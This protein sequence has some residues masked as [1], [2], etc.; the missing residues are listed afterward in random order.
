MF[1]ISLSLSAQRTWNGSQSSDWNTAANWTP[2]GVPGAADAVTIVSATNA[3]II[4]GTAQCGKFRI[5][6]GS[7]TLIGAGN[8]LTANSGVTI[9][10]GLLNMGADTSVKGAVLNVNAGWDNLAGLNSFHSGG[11]TVVFNSTNTISTTGRHEAF[12]NLVINSAM[13]MS[14]SVYVNKLATLNAN[15]T[16]GAFPIVY[17]ESAVSPEGTGY[18]IGRPV[19]F[20][21]GDYSIDIPIADNFGSPPRIFNIYFNNGRPEKFRLEYFFQNPATAGYPA[22]SVISEFN[23]LCWVDRNEWWRITS[24]TDGA[25]QVKV[26][27]YWNNPGVIRDETMIKVVQWTVGD[28]GA[29]GW[30]TIGGTGEGSPVTIGDVTSDNTLTVSAS[31]EGTPLAFGYMAPLLTPILY[32]EPGCEVTDGQPVSITAY[33]IDRFLNLRWY[34]AEFGG[35]LISTDFV[36]SVPVTADAPVT[37]WATNNIG[38]CESPRTPITLFIFHMPVYAPSETYTFCDDGVSLNT[39]TIPQ[40]AGYDV[41][42]YLSAGGS[43]AGFSNAGSLTYHFTESGTI[44][45]L[46]HNLWCDYYSP[47]PIFINV[48]KKPTRPLGTDSSGCAPSVITLLVES[49]ADRPNSNQFRWYTS[50]T[51]DD[52]LSG[53]TGSAYTTTYNTT[54]SYWVAEIVPGTECASK[55]TKVTATVFGNV[56]APTAQADALCAPGIGHIIINAPPEATGYIVWAGPTGSAQLATSPNSSVLVPNV[57]ATMTVYAGYRVKGCDSPR[58]PVEITLGTPPVSP[59]GTDVNFCRTGPL[60][61]TASSAV[62]G[63]RFTWVNQ[64]RRVIPGTGPSVTVNVSTN[65]ESFFVKVIDANGCESELTEIIAHYNANIPAPPDTI[66]YLCGN[67]SGIVHVP[68]LTGDTAWNWY[69]TLTSTTP[70]GYHGSDLSI[71]LDTSILLYFVSTIHGECESKRAVVIAGPLESPDAPAFGDSLMPCIGNDANLHLKFN[72]FFNFSEVL[73]GNLY[74]SA[75]ETV[76]LY[77]FT[78]P[79]MKYP[80]P[81]PGTYYFSYTN[82]HGCEGPRKPYVVTFNIAPEPPVFDALP[83]FCYGGAGIV[84]VLPQTPAA[85]H[86]E[87]FI[88]RSGNFRSL[89]SNTTGQFAFRPDGDFDTLFATAYNLETCPSRHAF[90]RVTTT[91][92][93]TPVAHDTV[94]CSGQDP[95]LRVLNPDPTYTYEWADP[96]GNVI[97][98]GT[99]L[100]QTLASGISFYKVSAKFDGCQSSSITVKATISPSPVI[101]SVSAAVICGFGKSQITISGG[102][103]NIW[104]LYP[105]STSASPLATSTSLRF[106]SHNISSAGTF[107]FFVGGINNSGCV[108]VRKRVTIN[109][110]PNSTA[111]AGR[112]T[113]AC[114]IN[115]VSLHGSVPPTPRVGSWK[116][117]SGGLGAFA[118]VHDPNSVFLGAPGNSYVLTWSYA[119]LDNCPYTE[120]EVSLKI[121]E[122]ISKPTLQFSANYCSDTRITITAGGGE[123]GEYYWSQQPLNHSSNLIFNS[124]SAGTYNMSVYLKRGDCQSQPIEFSFLVYPTQPPAIVGPDQKICSSGSITLAAQQPRDNENGIWTI[125][126]GLGGSLTSPTA[127]N[128]AFYGQVGNNYRLKWSLTV[129]GSPC[130]PTSASMSVFIQAS[131]EAPILTMNTNA[132]TNK[133]LTASAS[134]IGSGVYNWELV[135]PDGTSVT[136]NGTGSTQ[137]FGQWINKKTTGRWTVKVNA[138]SGN[139]I[140]PVSTKTFNVY[141]LPNADAG[142]DKVVFPGT[143][144]NLPLAGSA[145]RTWEVTS[146]SRGGFTLNAPPGNT[147]AT[148]VAPK[149][150][151]TLKLTVTGD[152]GCIAEDDVTISVEDQ[153]IVY[154]VFTPNTDRKNDTWNIGRIGLFPECKVTIF[155]RWDEAVYEST[156]YTQ[157]WDGTYK[158]NDLPAGGYV[159]QIVLKPGDAPFTGTVTL[160]R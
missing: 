89:G 101:D 8:S 41:F 17:T 32:T 39:I 2:A 20:R 27:L 23:E 62:P 85:S 59:T 74:T 56:T 153:V 150:T 84:R 120:D 73:T 16:S 44:T 48:D 12:W 97:S 144:V 157:P 63:A 30:R 65:D 160:T 76:P 53:V 5:N 45:M 126:S 67:N 98:T 77:Q 69:T 22:T 58:T 119:Q 21:S 86:Y 7:L 37:V 46:Y 140:G 135:S 54:T 42:P 9:A 96:Q 18:N 83:H 10:G 4:T 141:E 26:R 51:G 92:V 57:N 6:S 36:V 64:H 110:I 24:L 107:T 13:T 81:T 133:S 132:C 149:G 152:G 95:H 139:C 68:V 99:E 61:L 112:D 114:Q 71:T 116:I 38:N 138:I 123:E 122:P 159:Y 117:K 72:N 136:L 111:N 31:T 142:P 125:E 70:L 34:D 25:A 128:S 124:L 66:I 143:V 75:T 47:N 29:P 94:A 43:T 151:Y 93:T 52:Y 79:E 134:G 118:D 49:S 78:T 145:N 137:T 1:C 87:F 50:E 105:D 154:N 109:V 100:N 115:S 121:A 131:L 158:G 15:V 60:T 102:G 35:N 113:V 82:E 14:D 130:P 88:R 127:Y 11:G 129:T 146:I 28:N 147:Q 40:S 19:V 90:I 3:A 80:V 156:G 108:S 155:N 55:R 106:A 104:Y 148:F 33:P 103:A 91:E